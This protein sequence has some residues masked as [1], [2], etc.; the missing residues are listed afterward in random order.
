MTI[1]A[2]LSLSPGVVGASERG[3]GRPQFA[4]TEVTADEGHVTMQWELTEAVEQGSLG[5]TFELEQSDEPGF[6]DHRL[7]HRGA[8]RSFFVSGL[9]EGQTYFRVRAIAGG[10]AGPWS[11]T[12]AVEVAYPG[13]GRVIGL[14]IVGCLVFVATVVTIVLG[15][16]RYDRSRL[17][18]RRLAS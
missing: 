18:E 13:R 11:D 7:R 12:L 14:V 2:L 9:R 17:R 10:V 15:W 3:P 5:L 16:L 8:E 6:E 1:A 4:E